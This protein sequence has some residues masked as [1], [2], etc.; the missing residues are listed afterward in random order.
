MKKDVKKVKI[1]PRKLAR[2]MA[3][4]KL[5][6]QGATGYNKKIFLMGRRAPSRFARKWKELALQAHK[7]ALAREQARKPAPVPQRPMPGKKVYPT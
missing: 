5:D 6:K 4:A 7:E 2:S 1:S 3:R